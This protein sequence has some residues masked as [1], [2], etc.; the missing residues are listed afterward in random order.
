MLAGA[1]RNNFLNFQCK[2]EA[3][4]FEID[5]TIDEAQNHI[6]NLEDWVKPEPVQKDLMNKMYDCFIK[7]EPF[8]VCLIMGAWNYPVQ[9]TLFPVIGAISAGEWQVLRTFP[10]LEIP[11]SR[12][13]WS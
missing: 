13:D 6:N 12:A 3:F 10:G 1:L 9:L 4:I 11:A 5:L 2:Y 7:R 8:G